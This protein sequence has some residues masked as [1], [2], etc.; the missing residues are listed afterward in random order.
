MLA[1][2]K[3]KFNNAV[4]VCVISVITLFAAVIS[5]ENNISGEGNILTIATAMVGVVSFFYAIW[6]YVK[7][8]G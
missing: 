2:Y 4:W 6:A 5:E 3:S 1:E 7:A 8:R